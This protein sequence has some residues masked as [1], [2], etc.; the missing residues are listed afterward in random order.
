MFSHKSIRSRVVLVLTSSLVFGPVF[1]LS[2]SSTSSA[3]NSKSNAPTTVPIGTA[4]SY[5]GQLR[6]NG[7]AAN[8]LFD[9]K[10]RLYD[11]LVE[12]SQVGPEVVAPES[13]VAGGTFSADLDFGSVFQTK[14]WLEV[15]VNGTILSPRQSIMPTPTA[16]FALSGNNGP[17]GEKGETGATGSSGAPG[18]KGETGATGPAG[19]KG[20]KGDTGS[21]GANGAIG[22]TGSIGP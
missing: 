17:Q 22:L 6:Q 18:V 15:E 10:F 20:D 5:Q 21:T 19:A 7:Q 2:A 12:G 14:R 3:S 8:G 9:L 16:L 11:Q 1:P 4:F 13:D